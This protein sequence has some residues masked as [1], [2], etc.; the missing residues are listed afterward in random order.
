M[1]L[2]RRGLTGGLGA[3]WLLDGGLQLQPHMWSQAFFGATFENAN[4][5]LPSWLTGV[6]VHLDTWTGAHP[7]PWDMGIAVVQLAIGAALLAGRWVRP[8][9]ALSVVWAVSV[10]VFGEGMG[11]M[12]LSGANAMTGAPGAALLYALVAL[13]LWPRGDD[14]GR[15]AAD[16]GLL[17]P[18]GSRLL[19]AALWTAT[20]ALWLEYQSH[21][22]QGPGGQ[23]SGV[24]NGEPGWVSSINHHVGSAVGSN[25]PALASLLGALQLVAGLGVLLPRTRRVGLVVGMVVAVFYGVLGQDLGGLFT[26]AANDPGTG[27]VLVLWALALWPRRAPAPDSGL[28]SGSAHDAGVPEGVT[29]GLGPDR[30]PVG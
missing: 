22:A 27:P 26:G 23:L 5:A 18:L 12:S 20:A 28:D 15:A 4:V 14:D 19:W 8:A 17:R 25:G 24:G 7:L 10:W 3:L 16:S 30:Q 13:V 11:A 9:L 29:A 21:M 2:S 6:E 1:R